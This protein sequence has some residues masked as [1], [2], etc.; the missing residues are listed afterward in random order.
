[1][2]LGIEVLIAQAGVQFE[3]FVFIALDEP[4]LPIE[5]SGSDRHFDS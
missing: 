1:V 5:N 2:I 4:V 3:A